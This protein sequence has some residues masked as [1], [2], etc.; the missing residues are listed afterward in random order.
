MRWMF[1]NVIFKQLSRSETNVDTTAASKLSPA[2]GDL[3]SVKA[4]VY[5]KLHLQHRVRHTHASRVPRGMFF[6]STEK[7]V[8]GRCFSIPYTNLLTILIGAA[9]CLDAFIIIIITETEGFV[10]QVPLIF[11]PKQKNQ[12]P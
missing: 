5:G 10:P 2:N 11:H 1:F 6:T 9:L 4:D 7:K 12:T 8:Y 3:A